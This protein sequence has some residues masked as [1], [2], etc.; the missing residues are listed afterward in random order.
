MATVVHT[1]GDRALPIILECFLVVS[2][3]EFSPL[4]VIAPEEGVYTICNQIGLI[5]IK[6]YGAILQKP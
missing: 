1:M 4:G 6:V 2:N 3:F 5:E